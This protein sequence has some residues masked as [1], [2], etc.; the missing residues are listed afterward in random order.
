MVQADIRRVWGYLIDPA[1]VVACVPGAELTSVEDAQRFHGRLKAKV[2][3]VSA[4]YAGTAVITGLDMEARTITI[5]AD[6]KEVGGS[7]SAK[8]R[9]TAELA[10]A[11]DGTEI[12]VV[13]TVDIVG[14]VM[15]FGRGMVEMVSKQLVSEFIA[16][17]RAT[18]EA[19]D[20]PPVTADAA[21]SAEPVSVATNAPPKPLRPLRSLMRAI[22][23]RLLGMFQRAPNT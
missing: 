8:L 5:T 18:L 14:R 17:I 20:Q 22:W 21:S 11:V 16:C 4:T 19:P 7:G 10:P 6:A 13:A 1:R 15:Q 9:V 3:P 12:H 2:G 23:Q